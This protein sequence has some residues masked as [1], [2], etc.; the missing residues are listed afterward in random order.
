MDSAPFFTQAW[1]RAIFTFRPD[2]SRKTSLCEGMRRMTRRNA[3]HLAMT[4]GRSCSSGRKRFFH[5]VLRPLQGSHDAGAVAAL[6]ASAAA[7]V[8]GGQL[9]GCR[10]P[11]LRHERLQLRQRHIR[12]RS[13]AL[14]TGAQEAFLVELPH[15]PLHGGFPHTEPPGQRRVRPLACLIRL[16]HP[17]PQL[18][19]IRLCHT[20][21]DQA[22]A[23]LASRINSPEHWG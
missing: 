15:P 3:S 2:S 17:L 4:S 9:A 18:D 21:S 23:P 8:R 7:V 5:H 16:D 13:T 22:S 19:G 14:L 20:P 10:I 12:G 11:Q 6:L 1:L